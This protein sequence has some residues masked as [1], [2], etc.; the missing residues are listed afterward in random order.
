LDQPRHRTVAIGAG[1][2]LQ[3]EAVERGQRAARGEFED[4]SIAG[5]ICSLVGGPVQFSIAGLDQRQLPF[6]PSKLAKVVKV[7]ACADWIIPDDASTVAKASATVAGDTSILEVQ[8]RFSDVFFIVDSV[9]ADF[10]SYE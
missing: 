8:F 10:S 9:R 5:P 7:C 2:A 1:R 4:V 6:V 3:A